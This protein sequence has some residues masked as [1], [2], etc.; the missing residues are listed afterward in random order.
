[1]PIR[2]QQS[3]VRG[4]QGKAIVSLLPSGQVQVSLDGTLYTFP[5]EACP[6][7]LI[8]GEMYV[9]LSSNLDQLYD[10]RPWQGTFFAKFVGF[11]RSEEGA[12]PEPYLKPGGM[13]KNSKTGRTFWVD[14]ALKFTAKFMVVNGPHRGITYIYPM[15]YVFRQYENTNETMLYGGK[16]RGYVETF[17]SLHGF[18]LEKDTIP[19]SDNVLP[20]IEHFI[21]QKNKFVTLTVLKGWISQLGD[22]PDGLDVTT[23]MQN[24]APQQ[25]VQPQQVQPQPQQPQ[26]PPYSLRRRSRHSRQQLN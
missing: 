11:S 17:L 24:P 6:S 12:Q 18:N 1:M 4:P 5:Q 13:R 20:Y 15:F 26:Q 25:V 7:P 16:A 23:F 10:C 8:P 21:L 3:N 9:S 22:L 14:D 2:S 19:W